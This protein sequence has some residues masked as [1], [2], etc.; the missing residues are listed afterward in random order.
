MLAEVSPV[1]IQETLAKV[2]QW[3][4]QV[5]CEPDP[6]IGRRGAVCPFVEPAMRVDALTIR[7][8]L[9]G[10]MPNASLVEETVRCALDEFETIEWHTS[11]PALRA[12]LVVIPDL[13]ADRLD[14]FDEAHRQ[15]KPESVRRGF[16][17]GQFHERC[18]EQ[19]AR[20][21][22]FLV[23]RSPVPVLAVRPMAVH[24]VLFLSG[25]REWFMEYVARFGD[26]YRNG[27]PGLDPMFIQIFKESLAKF[28][29]DHA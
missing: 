9:L 16:M 6:R 11:N 2:D 8:R 12:L 14:L 3:L 26:R 17:I 10:P 7:V 5:I 28:G 23:S 19:A 20:N 1:D 27:R 15:V 25:R 24:D 13:P 4:R 29:L 22:M 18:E 21:P